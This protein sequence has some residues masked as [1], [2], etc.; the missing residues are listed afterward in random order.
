M[1]ALTSRQSEILDFIQ[2]RSRDT[3]YPPTH[4]DIVQAFGFSS[5]NAARDHL[6]A[7]AR[8]GYIELVPNSAR[9]IRMLVDDRNALRDQMELPLIGRIAAG[10][11]VTAAEN[12]ETWMQIGPG[13]FSPRADFLH[14]VSGHSM[15]EAGIL[16]GDLVGIH[17]QSVAD[18]GQI[19]AAVMPD[20]KTGDDRITLKRYLR[21]GHR[22]V[23][24]AENPAPQYRPIEIDLARHGADSQEA[25]P[26]RIA[27]IYVGLIRIR[28]NH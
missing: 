6:Q 1:Q 7:L 3:G 20:E 15:C 13:V 25:L 12:V 2:T 21:R 23:L 5:R 8:K 18:N 14:Q 9:G 17:E 19:V 26:F 28:G 4:E 11:P 27:G 16:D 24:K 22:I 10:S